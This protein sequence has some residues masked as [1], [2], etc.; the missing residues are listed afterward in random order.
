[1]PVETMPAPA[2][3][4]AAAPPPPE[5][6]PPSPG[7]RPPSEWLSDIESD[8][9][10]LEAGKS[11]PQRDDKGKFKAPEKAAPV[12][13][14]AE[15]PPEK[16]V[17]RPP[18][19][20]PPEAPPAEPPKPVK[21][22]QL[23]EAYDGLKKRVR[24]ELEPQLQRL[25]AQVKDLESKQPQETA[26]ILEKI[27]ALEQRNAQ[28]ENQIEYVDF[29]QSREFET[30]YEAPYREAWNDAIGQFRSLKIRKPSGIDENTGEES[31]TLEPADENTLLA[32]AN[33]EDGEMD[34]TAHKWFGVSAPRVIQRVEKVKDL[35]RQRMK[36]LEEAKTKGVE[37]K[38][39]RITEFQERTKYLRTTWE[40]INKALKEK[41]PKAYSPEEGNAEDAGAHTKGFALA[42]L[43]F[44][45]G[46]SLTPEQ[47][48]ALPAS[49]RESVKSKKPLSEDQKVQLHA[50]ARLKI[51]NHDRK[52]VA[53]RKAMTRIAELE[54]ALAEY[55][56]STPKG[57]RTPGAPR[58]QSKDWQDEIA[59]ELKALDK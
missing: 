16:P 28:L 22:A 30:K 36:A 37:W 55:E 10:D 12:A 41:F 44:L 58:S 33:M 23:R 31:F 53:L 50:L 15:K 11:P 54:K 1:M 27:K 17:E 14:P 9:S 47:V 49:F 42:D 57:G 8:L 46:E 29:S 25:Q 21:A 5:T 45:G 32:L 6:P 34:E 59:D 24:E 43:M 2:A 39:K 7:E 40:E 35:F 52:V 13:K 56:D 19:E 38:T 51:A 48:E 4:P 18:D 26:P 20:K 3:A